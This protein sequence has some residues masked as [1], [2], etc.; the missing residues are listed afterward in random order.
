[1]LL[2]NGFAATLALLTARLERKEEKLSRFKL[3]STQ[4]TQCNISRV[5]ASTGRLFCLI[6]REKGG[7]TLV[8]VTKH[9]SF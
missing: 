2:R 9:T 3:A 1:M 8:K 6:T 5:S 7:T 4:S